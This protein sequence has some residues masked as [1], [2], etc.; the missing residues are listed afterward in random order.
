MPD[1]ATKWC[2]LCAMRNAATHT[3]RQDSPTGIPVCADHASHFTEGW[4]VEPIQPDPDPVIVHVA[5][6]RLPSAEAIMAGAADHAPRTSVALVMLLIDGT[7]Q[8]VTEAEL[9]RYAT[10]VG[11]RVQRWIAPEHART[12]IVSEL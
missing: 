9:D 7:W 2:E 10:K 6:I 8:T 11:Q 3:I 4:T 5:E 1:T 12:Y